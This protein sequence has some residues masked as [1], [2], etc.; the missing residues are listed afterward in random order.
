MDV[1]IAN[2]NAHGVGADDH[3]FDQCMW[4]VAHDV[5]VFERTRLALIAIANQILLA[6]EL[7]GHK[8]PLQS[9]RKACAPTTAQ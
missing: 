3:A 4:V 8:A 2:A 1:V 6:W 5:T 7:T 9:C